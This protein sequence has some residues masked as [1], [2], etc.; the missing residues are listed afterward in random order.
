MRIFLLSLICFAATHRVHAQAFLGLHGT[1]NSITQIKDNPAFTVHEEKFEFNYLGIG[2]EAGGNSVHFRRKVMGYLLNGN[3]ALGDDYTRNENS[4]KE[5]RFW[6]NFEVL[7]PSAAFLVKKRYFFAVST[8][9]RYMVNSDNLNA[10]VADMLGVN[11]IV[12]TTGSGSRSIDNYNITA[13]AFSELGLSYGGYF[14]ESQ[15]H[16]IEGGITVSLISGAGAAGLGIPNASFNAKRGDG[17]AYGLRGIANVAYTPY[18]NDWALT[19]NPFNPFRHP[20]NNFGYGISAGAVYY[21]N[22]R[23]GPMPKKGYI[24]RVAISITDVGRVSYEASALSGTY[25]VTDSAFNYR[26]VKNQEGVTFGNRLFNDYIVTGKAVPLGESSSRFTVGLPTALRI[27]GDI[28]VNEK[29][30]VNGN[31]IINLRRPS[32]D[33]FATHYVTTITVAPRYR[34]GH[35]NLSVPVCINGDMQGYMGAVVES[36]VIYA[37]STSLVQF[38]ASNKINNINFFVGSHLKIPFKKK[39]SEKDALMF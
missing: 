31:F 37:G 35:I 22:P 21:Y 28:K 19:A 27:N 6:G 30:F 3:A 32:A 20:M 13:H 33:V 38:A 18:A 1:D 26:A 24:A 16:N 25:R 17:T 29:L 4:G 5:K 9:M 15:E 36:G 11:P 10:Q 39:Q 7:G 2:F 8:R 23:T 14:L 12:D 34:F